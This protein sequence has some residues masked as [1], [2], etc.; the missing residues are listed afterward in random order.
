[1]PLVTPSRTAA[2]VVAALAAALLL[3]LAGPATAAPRTSSAATTACGKATKKLRAA[4]SRLK[5]VQRK[6]ARG[7]ASRAAVAR[8]RKAVKR[9]TAAKRRACRV[10]AAPSVPPSTPSPQPAPSPSPQPPPPPPPPPAPPTSH[11]LIQKALDEGR[12][13]DEIALRYFVFSEFGDSR[14]PQEFRGSSLDATDTDTL[15]EVSRRWDQLSPAT[16]DVLD[17]FFIPPFNPGS[18]YDLGSA[19]A[20]RAGVAAE[21]TTGGAPGADLCANTAPDMARWGYVTAVGGKV[22]VWYENTVAG[23][24]DKAIAVAQY[25]DAGAWTKVISA[26]REPHQ[27]G[28][29]LDGKRCR[30]FDPA[31]DMVLSR[32][33]SVYGRAVDY[34][35]DG[36][37]GPGPGFMLINRTLAGK[38]LQSTVVHELAH[39]A[40]FAYSADFCTTGIGWLTEATAAWTENYVGG[41][42]PEFPERFAPY[43]WDR[44]GLPLETYEPSDGKPHQ[45]GSYL[46]FQWLSKNK[47]AEALGKVWY[48]TESGGH[49]VDTTQ[50]ALR[51][52]GFAGG[53]DEA[54]KRFALAGLNPMQ[55][56]DWF[57]QWGMPRGALISH[58]TVFADGEGVKLPVALPHLSAQ[59]HDLAFSDAVKGIEVDNPLVGV[60][61]ASV[62][63]WLRVNDGGQERVEIRDIS[64]EDRT[65]FCRDI[66]PENVQ[67]IALVI[68][69]ST[70]ADRAGVL[71]GDVNVRGTRSCG[72]YDATATATI[73]QDGLTEVYTAS[74]TM[75]PQWSIPLDGGGTETF[76]QTESANDMHA[77][78]SISGVS[79][80]DGCTYSG[81]MSWPAGDFGLQ[82]R[83]DLHDFGNGDPRTLYDHGF[84]VPFKVGSAHRSCP[85]GHSDDLYWQLGHGFASQS[86]PWDPEG[87]G[88]T[89]SETQDAGGVILEH[90]WTL[91]RK[92]VGP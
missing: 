1:M 29:D 87:Q 23:Q 15:D 64:S 47:G 20:A 14:L 12:I 36:C 25:L 13:D 33:T 22:R 70:S 39:L 56:V 78:W 73:K 31:V 18:W 9:A 19:A 69:N 67:E 74:Y 63:A 21:S 55:K 30:G 5:A 6:A 44:P 16:R 34:F 37:K 72:A 28:G 11:A 76:F 60:P 68:A 62:Q 58:D 83:L 32:I 7:R 84:G 66:Q 26:F 65:T 88:M 86:H 17:P 92:Q 77:T 41:L 53:F 4:K 46:F 71:K 50:A 42:G 91:S 79:N 80:S 51:D 2:A 10:P 75:K 81:S 24:L 40:H 35:D 85:N 57:K 49:P 38:A 43:F 59:Y 61:G 54:W 8:A 27:D 89:G 82:A 48:Y 90:D 52:L 45:Y 3:A